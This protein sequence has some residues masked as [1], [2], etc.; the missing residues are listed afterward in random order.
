MNLG[1]WTRGEP[2]GCA[3]DRLR[4]T[5]ADFGLRGGNLK[6]LGLSVIAFVL[7]LRGAVAEAQQP[8][9][10]LRIGVLSAGSRSSTLSDAFHQGLRELGYVEGQNV[11]IE[12][13]NADGDD[14]RL[15]GLAADLVRLKVDILIAAGGNEV[16]RAL[17][18]ATNSTPIVM[19]A[20][21]NAVARGLIASLARPGGN[22]TGLTSL[23]DDLSGKRLELL[24]ETIPKLSRVAVL[25]HSSGGR[26]TQWKAS[27]T[28]AQQLGLQLHS[29]EL[30]NAA[31]LE[32]A[33]NRAVM[34][35][36][37]AL[38][39]TQ[40]SL[41]SINLQNIVRLAIRHRLPAIYAIPEH[42]EAGGLMAYGTNRADLYRRAAV[43]VD[44]ILRGAKPANLPVEQ[45]TTFELVINLETAKAI[46]LAI[47]PNVLA[48]ADRVIK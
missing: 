45:P 24:K 47:P 8:K 33:F 20:G 31:D 39:V 34:A 38:A 9:K 19:T 26:A 7:L 3:Q 17:Q 1:F 10:L 48:R 37:S 30:R 12:Y 43:Y 28:T 35:R 22:V 6:W 25:W 23:W 41:V 27:Q 46:G 15:P 13:R 36:S 40:T 5:I 11:A 29:M 32:N 14:D 21:S 16:T 4:R 2:F 42:A 44:K 18:R